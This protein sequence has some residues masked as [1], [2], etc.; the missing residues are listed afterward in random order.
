MRPVAPAAGLAT[1]ENSSS[2]LC[3]RRRGLLRGLVRSRSLG[4]APGKVARITGHG[5]TRP[6]QAL[7]P[8]PCPPKDHRQPPLPTGIPPF[9]GDDHW[10]HGLW[11]RGGA[12]RC[13]KG[14]KKA[15][16][17]IAK[18]EG[19]TLNFSTRGCGGGPKLRPM[20]SGPK[21]GPVPSRPGRRP[22]PSHPIRSGPCPVR[23]EDRLLPGQAET[24]SRPGQR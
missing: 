24:P 4:R 6:R 10:R 16:K 13:E 21:L 20:P 5:V 22:V 15:D 1:A 7:H 2:R 8:H 14:M 18:G 17:R 19:G 9:L 23:A 11:G 12:E 3:S